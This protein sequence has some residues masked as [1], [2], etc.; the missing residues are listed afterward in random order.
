MHI[1][2]ITKNIRYRE[3]LEDYLKFAALHIFASKRLIGKP[4]FCRCLRF[5]YSNYDNFIVVRLNN[6]TM[7]KLRH[8]KANERKKIEYMLIAQHPTRRPYNY[9][10][11]TEV[12]RRKM[13]LYLTGYTWFRCCICTR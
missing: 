9:T 7:R 3:N 13:S 4:A 12:V 2:F 5:N 1:L 8:W 6:V 11:H 10:P